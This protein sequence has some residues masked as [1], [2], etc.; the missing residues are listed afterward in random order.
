MIQLRIRASLLLRTTLVVVGLTLVIGLL[1]LALAGRV[2]GRWELAHQLEV[3]GAQADGVESVA[4]AAC[5]VEDRAL[6]GQIVQRLVGTRT[7]QAAVL[8]SR[9]GILAQASRGGASKAAESRSLSRSIPSP[10]FKEVQVGQLDLVPDLGEAE[11]QGARTAVLLRMVVFCLAAA[12][13]LA[14]AFTIQRSIIRPI[15]LLS[16]RLHRLQA[17]SGALLDPPPGHDRDEIG[18]LVW[19]VNFLLGRLVG[20]IRNEHALSER[21]LLDQGKVQAILNNVSAGVFVADRKGALEAWTPAF[22][23]ML[24]LE[25][26]IRGIGLPSLFGEA[27]VLVGRCL[28]RCRATGAKVTELVR[29]READ[30]GDHR[31]YRLSLDPIEADAIQGQLEDV[32]ALRN[33][34]DAA[35]ELA[36]RD[37]LTGA[38]NRLGAENALAE[39]LGKGCSGLALMMADLDFFKLVNDT[40]GHDAGDEVLRQVTMRMAAQLRDTD[41][42]ARLGG[43][44]FLLILDDLE[45][46]ALALDI[47]LKV[48]QAIGA[49]ISL[50]GGLAT[51]V[52]ASIGIVLHDAMATPSRRILLKRADLAMYQAKQ[53]GRNCAR[54][55]SGE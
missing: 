31:W 4:G 27:G 47:A 18:R 38:L 50:P 49:P 46:E 10:F 54:V 11:R 44:E 21:V 12:L 9:T 20:A 42:V 52:G 16:D 37:T 29:V 22:L 48:I 2:A 15:A 34:T 45:D 30:G 33:A 26:G 23:R 35:Q 14:L 51:Q 40:F 25:H 41:V 28:D 13:G 5:F 43:D 19:D 6:A 17:E 53:A 36:L 8:R 1:A 39:R 3:M 7:I 24:G 32:T 55:F